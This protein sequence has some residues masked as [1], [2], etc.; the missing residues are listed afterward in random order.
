MYE[1]MH[2]MS[3]WELAHRWV[4][5]DPMTTEGS[6]IPLAVQPMLRALSYAVAS[7]RLPASR[8][9]YVTWD[10]PGPYT[11]RIEALFDHEK[12]ELTQADLDVLFSSSPNRKVLDELFV[13][14]Y[15]VFNWAV[16]QSP[17]IDF[18]DFIVPEWAWTNKGEGE[19]PKEQ[20]EVKNRRPHEEALDKAHCQG[21]AIALWNL[22]PDMPIAQVSEHQAYLMA[23]GKNYS[24]TTRYKWA[25]E[26]APESV[27]GRAGRP[28]AENKQP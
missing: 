9:A 22:H 19:K 8:P 4:D 17:K 5:A 20:I 6:P 26:V 25:R 15:N 7:G 18:P 28:K 16:E 3:I 27:K 2:Y 12:S 14:L 21:A 1:T 10:E 11:P 23:G 24:D 13:G